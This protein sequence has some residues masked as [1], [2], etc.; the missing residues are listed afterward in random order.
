LFPNIK[1]VSLDCQGLSS[2]IYP[3]GMDKGQLYD[4][5]M[6]IFL[7]D[8][9]ND[10]V[11]DKDF[12]KDKFALVIDLQS[13]RDTHLMNTG[14]RTENVRDGISIRIEKEPTTTD[15]DVRIFVLADASIEVSDNTIG[16]LKLT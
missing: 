3:R 4:E 6:R 2:Y 7:T 9:N 13:Y 5:A 12:Y 8:K 15:L 10:A 1:K 11:L 16:E 14:T